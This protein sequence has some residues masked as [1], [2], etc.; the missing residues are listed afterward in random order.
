MLLHPG[1]TGQGQSLVEYSLLLALVALVALGALALLGRGVSRA[2]EQAA[3]A[4]SVQDLTADFLGRIN[5]FY[6]LND[7]W[8]RSWGDAR[9]TDLGLDPADWSQP[10]AGVVWNPNGPRIGLANRPGDNLQIYVTDRDN[11]VRKL[12]DGWNIWCEAADGKCYYHTV[13]PENEVDLST[14]VVREE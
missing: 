11:K 6:Q 2:F 9:F 14:L 8:P 12:Y 3:G 13:A 10:V 1:K 5:A 7:R 4:P